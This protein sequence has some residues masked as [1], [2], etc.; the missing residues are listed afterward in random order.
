MPRTNFIQPS[1]SEKQ[2]W[3]SPA[4]VSQVDQ[5]WKPF[6]VERLIPAKAH[7]HQGPKCSDLVEG[8]GAL[9]SSRCHPGELGPDSLDKKELKAVSSVLE[10]SFRNQ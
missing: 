7:R 8:G 1:G 9:S 10:T 6:P 5:E 4:K 3:L 2:G